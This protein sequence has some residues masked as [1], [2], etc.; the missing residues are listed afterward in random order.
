MEFDQQ[1]WDASKAVPQDTGGSDRKALIFLCADGTAQIL[2]ANCKNWNTESP[3]LPVCWVCG[4]N[5][6]Q[7]FANFGLEGTILGCSEVVLP[8]GAIHRHIAANSR[9]PHYGLRRVLCVGIC[10]MSG[11][12]SPM[13]ATTGKSM[14]VVLRNLF[15][16][17][18]T[19]TTGA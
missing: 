10:G 16:P 5:R 15:R 8:I 11:M 7:Y 1:L 19:C 2:L 17:I 3:Q 9:I 6:A 18:L 12:C 4:C 13:A 14:S